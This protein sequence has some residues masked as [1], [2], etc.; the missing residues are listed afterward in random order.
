MDAMY[1]LRRERTNIKELSRCKGY[2]ERSESR[3]REEESMAHEIDS[4]SIKGFRKAHLIQLSSYIRQRD[5]NEW[6]YGPKAQ[7]E[8][9]HADLLRFAD[10]LDSLYDDKSLRIAKA[11]V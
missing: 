5:H 10:T 9:R 6:Y 3:D 4:V 1:S 2:V 11:G 7:F 8:A